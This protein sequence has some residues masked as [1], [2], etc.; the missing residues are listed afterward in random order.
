M[1]TYDDPW[2]AIGNQLLTLSGYALVMAF[3]LK[4]PE[5]VSKLVFLIGFALLAQSILTDLTS[6]VSQAARGAGFAEN[7][8]S[9]ALRLSLLNIVC[10]FFLQQKRSVIIFIA[11]NFV[12]VFLT[13]SRSGIIMFA[14]STFLI[15]AVKFGGITRLSKLPVFF[16]RSLPVAA[17][18]TAFFFLI[19]PYLTSYFPSFESRGAAQRISQITGQSSLIDDQDVGDQGRVAIAEKYFGLILERP[20]GYG[21]GMSMNREFYYKATH[22]MY[23]RVG[24]DY[25][26]FGLIILITIILAGVYR[27]VRFNDVYGLSFYMTM[28]IACFFTNTLFEN[29]TFVFCWAYIDA[30]ALKQLLQQ[31]KIKA[32]DSEPIEA[33]A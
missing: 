5:R 15:V 27:S 19:I 30:I 2:Y 31:R 18:L 11:I 13:L 14:L 24:I 6:G 12:F 33:L 16:V 7:P 10:L 29:R 21:T 4:V 28:L 22:N 20:F 25:G 9:A 26:I 3:F 17:M 8:N 1:S 32:Y 23:L